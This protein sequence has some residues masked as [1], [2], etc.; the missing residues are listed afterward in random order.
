M[1]TEAFTGAFKNGRIENE[2]Q[3]NQSQV[4]VHVERS[5]Y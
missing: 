4:T 3:E 2:F 1:E 5:I